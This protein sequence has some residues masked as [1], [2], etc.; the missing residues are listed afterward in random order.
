VTETNRWPE[1]IEDR[2]RRELAELRDRRY[3]RERLA[4]V[5]RVKRRVAKR[6]A[7]PRRE[8]EKRIHLQ[9]D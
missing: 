9:D 6:L 4:R 2:L 1:S 3:E 7:T 5:A 8:A